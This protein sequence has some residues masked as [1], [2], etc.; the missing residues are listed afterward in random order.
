MSMAGAS[1]VT[2]SSLQALADKR[3]ARARELKESRRLVMGGCCQNS[4]PM[5]LAVSALIDYAYT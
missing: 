1:G 4:S 5:E 3:V 2:G